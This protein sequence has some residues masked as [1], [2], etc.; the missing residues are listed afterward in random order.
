MTNLQSK[1]SLGHDVALHFVAASGNGGRSKVEVAR[2]CSNTVGRP[3]SGDILTNLAG[4][5]LVYAGV[6][7]HG[8]YHQRAR[9]L[10]HVCAERFHH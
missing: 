8:L 7:A 4:L 10:S 2:K 5:W 3:D 6:K 1:H 9:M